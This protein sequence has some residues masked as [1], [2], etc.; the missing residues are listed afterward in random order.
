MPALVYTYLNLK[1]FKLYFGVMLTALILT[2]NLTCYLVFLGIFTFATFHFL[3]IFITVPIAYY[4]FF[5]V[6]PTFSTNFNLRFNDT[7][8]TLSGAND[9]F[10]SRLQVNSTTLSLLSNFE[11]AKFTL[12]QNPLTGGGIGGHEEMYFR[13]FGNTSFSSNYYYGLNAKAAHSLSIRILSELGLIGSA[14]YIYVLVKNLVFSRD[15]AQYAISI[16]CLS[17]FLCKSFK[18]GG[19][20]DYGTPFFFTILILNARAF[21]RLYPQKLVSADRKN[22][23]VPV[24]QAS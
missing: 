8:S 11:V 23:T 16:G 12:S 10:S 5:N 1:Q 13:R 7:F 22:S 20:I 24:H 19:Y 9:I 6:L 18:L 4:L 14:L 17:H 3:Y 15:T 21:R 2:Y